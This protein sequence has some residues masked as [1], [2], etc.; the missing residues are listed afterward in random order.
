MKLSDLV[1]NVELC[2]L[3][4]RE[5][6]F[7]ASRTPSDAITPY[8]AE[9]PRL[10]R[11]RGDAAVDGRFSVEGRVELAAHSDP[12]TDPWQAD[13]TRLW[14]LTACAVAEYRCTVG[15][16]PRAV[17]EAFTHTSARTHLTAHLRVLAQDA[18]QRAGYG[19]LLL[20]IEAVVGS[21]GD[22]GGEAATVA[23]TR[24][25]GPAALRF[26]PDVRISPEIAAL[27]VRRD[28]IVRLIE[29]IVDVVN[30]EHWHDDPEG[31]GD[32]EGFMW[33]RYLLVAVQDAAGLIDAVSKDPA[34]ATILADQVETREA[35]ARDRA[36][37]KE[38]LGGD[39]LRL[40]RN[41][42]AAHVDP[43]RIRDVLIDTGSEITGSLWIADNHARTQFDLAHNVL[44]AAWAATAGPGS[45]SAADER[46][47]I[48]DLVARGRDAG[49][50]V[51]EIVPRLLWAYAHVAWSGRIGASGGDD[52]GAVERG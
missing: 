46:A 32:Y 33:A 8:V 51:L 21:V 25:E 52:A 3:R 4:T 11:L 43:R 6:H 16:P 44:L 17:L 47:V 2:D 23:Y 24:F 20:P 1:R 42:T 37:L 27:L 39:L 35:L 7:V 41:K 12:V 40:L 31:P 9:S 14:S 49:L 29:R 5:S 36:R 38:R 50:A 13:D 45:S 28:E 48:G 15:A 19:T 18:V 30:R 22:A 26:A 34:V 10:F